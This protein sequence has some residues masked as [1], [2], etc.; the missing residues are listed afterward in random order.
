MV[1]GLTQDEIAELARD[2]HIRSEVMQQTQDAPSESGPPGYQEVDNTIALQMRILD[3]AESKEMGNLMSR[4][5]M[6]AN[7]SDGDK[8]LVARY[9]DIAM[10]MRDLK[11]H[12][13]SLHF[14]RK[15]L[16]VAGVSRG[17]HGFQQDK[18]NEKREIKETTMDGLRPTGS[19][20]P[21]RRGK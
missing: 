15:A 7:L 17:A 14:Y 13:S 8:D 4:D 9:I 18:L 2:N 19:W 16:I 11:L 1:E 21:L 6:L 10:R 20:N 3:Q 5:I 12:N